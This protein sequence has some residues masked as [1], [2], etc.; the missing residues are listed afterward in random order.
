MSAGIV[1]C[2]QCQPGLLLPCHGLT[3]NQHT[4]PQRWLIIDWW[5][6]TT[7]ISVLNNSLMAAGNGNVLCSVIV[8]LTNCLMIGPVKCIIS[9]ST[10]LQSMMMKVLKTIK[11]F[12]HSHKKHTILIKLAQFLAWFL[13][14]VLMGPAYGASE[15]ALKKWAVLYLAVLDPAVYIWRSTCNIDIQHSLLMSAF[16]QDQK[17]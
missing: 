3:I 1:L 5:N 11:V 17:I 2:S 13:N 7:I 12:H 4:S 6:G 16:I 9:S 15:N 14:F 8:I 10:L